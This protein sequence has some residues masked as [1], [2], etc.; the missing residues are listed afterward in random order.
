MLSGF[1]AGLRVVAGDPFMRRVLAL[2]ALFALGGRGL[3][4][5]LPAIAD[6]AFARGAAGLGTLTSAAGL[7]AL[8]ASF[9]I[10]ALPAAQPGKLPLW[11]QAGV[12][13]GIGIS[14]ALTLSPSW[15]LALGLAAALGGASAVVGV[16]MQ[17]ALQL[18]VAD[19]YRGRIMSLWVM[20]G[21]GA[22]A[23]G[24]L[25][26]GALADLVGLAAGCALVYGAGFVL[27]LAGTRRGV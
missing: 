1:R 18:V 10:V 19:D 8:A 4:E 26:I 9:G 17:S 13:M 15:P 2:T 5:L 7:G 24:A 23:M 14:L 20:T 6:G 22:A 12:W 3:L 16:S 27:F 11:G 25:L 21:L